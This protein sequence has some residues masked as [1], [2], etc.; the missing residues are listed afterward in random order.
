M[1]W[2]Q[3]TASVPAVGFWGAILLVT[4][5]GAL[6]VRRLRGARPRLLGMFT[7]AVVLLVP[8]SARALPYT[9][10]N[11]TIADAAQVNANFA[12]V[13]AG[14]GLAPTASAN[15]VDL[16][17][18]H[19]SCPGHT[20]GTYYALDQ[21]IGANGGQTSFSIPNGQTLVLSNL[22]VS[23]SQGASSANRLILVVAY[24][25]GPTAGAVI[26]SELVL[27]N[28]QGAGAATLSFGTG[29]PFG[30]GSSV[31][32]Y[33]YDTGNNNFVPPYAASAHG[34]MTTQ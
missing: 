20:A 10:T 23:L 28:A 16:A 8:I 17:E 29:S 4:L 32:V 7:L 21:V 25:Q 24:R 19:N 2:G 34:F 14:Q 3:A 13:V 11:G 18:I 6:G 22:N 5:L 33:A 27:L 30:A 31:C 1:N 26:D 12:A 9:F 15:L